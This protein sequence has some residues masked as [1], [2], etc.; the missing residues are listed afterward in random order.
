MKHV[1]IIL[2]LTAVGALPVLYVYRARMESVPPPPP[3]PHKNP[4]IFAKFSFQ[5]GSCQA[6][7][8]RS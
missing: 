3:E 6:R 7:G 2:T 5:P 1:M 8:F 4:R